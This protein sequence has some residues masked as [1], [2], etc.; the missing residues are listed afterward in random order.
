MSEVEG[1]QESLKDQTMENVELSNQ[2]VAHKEKLIEINAA[3]VE[4]IK[5]DD[6]SML[7]KLNVEVE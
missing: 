3:I 7:Y 6:I 2:L 1:L 4:A 5:K